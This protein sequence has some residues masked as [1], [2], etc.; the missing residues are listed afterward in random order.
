M[1]VN[2]II[3]GV[4][5]SIIFFELTDITPGGIVVP[6]LMVLY[7]NEPLRLCLTV[8]IAIATYFIIMLMSK[9]FLIYGKRRFALS[10]LI[11]FSLFIII[12]LLI[13]IFTSTF[14]LNVVQVIGYTTAG[15]IA[16]N[17]FRQKVIKTVVSL[18]IVIGLLELISLLFISFGA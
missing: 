4:I 10:I 17:M 14:S 1:N 15:I 5:I 12:N 16:N 3:I 7:I 18:G 9:R 13:S 8:L 6:G 11:S 2:I